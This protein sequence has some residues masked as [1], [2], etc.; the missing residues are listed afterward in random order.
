MLPYGFSRRAL[1]AASG[2]SSSPARA[3]AAGPAPR[4]LA[5]R[6]PSAEDIPHGTFGAWYYSA[7]RAETARSRDAVAAPAQDERLTGACGSGRRQQGARYRR[8]GPSQVA[9]VSPP[10]LSSSLALYIAAGALDR[11]TSAFATG[12]A[13]GLGLKRGEKVVL[14]MSNEVEHVRASLANS[15]YTGRRRRGRHLLFLFCLV[16]FCF[17]RSALLLFPPLPCSWPWLPRRR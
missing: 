4:W 9:S 6:A 10:P 11:E 15:F 14:W 7:L 2:A 1:S 5:G 12:L 13:E 17:N 3:A 16:L 8:R